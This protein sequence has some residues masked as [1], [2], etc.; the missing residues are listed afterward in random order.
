MIQT[1][2]NYL[3]NENVVVMIQI[4]KMCGGNDSDCENVWQ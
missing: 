1:V 4:M 2:M 3:G